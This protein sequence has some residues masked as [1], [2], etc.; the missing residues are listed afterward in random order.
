MSDPSKPL[1]KEPLGPGMTQAILDWHEAAPD[2]RLAH[3][4]R[5]AGASFSSCSIERAARS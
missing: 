2:D 3:L 1:P 5:D 4:M